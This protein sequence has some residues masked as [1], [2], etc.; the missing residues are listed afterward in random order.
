MNR[1]LFCSIRAQQRQL[2]A[3]RRVSAPASRS[4]RFELLEDRRMLTASEQT[5]YDFS[6]PLIDGAYP[7]AGLVADG[8]ILFGT[9]QS[10]GTDGG[11]ELDGTLFEINPN[12]NGFQ[13]LHSFGASQ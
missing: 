13:V 3:R 1:W 8:S 2:A 12:D 11:S 9:T 5:L 7:Q 6:D 10:G 4:T